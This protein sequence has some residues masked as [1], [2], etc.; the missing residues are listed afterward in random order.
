[1]LQVD[2]PLQSDATMV[3][4]YGSPPYDS[5]TMVGAGPLAGGMDTCQGDSG[6]PL[7]VAGALQPAVVGD[8][9]W[10]AGCAR[11]NLPG[12]YGESW[13]GQMRTFINN[14]V[15]RPANDN[16]ILAQSL[17]GPVGRVSGNN[18]DSTGEVGEPNSAGSAA[19]TT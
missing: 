6:G 10:G 11:A 16:F 7:F 5:A 9:S 8:T 18:T 13:D 15:T 4:A 17:S 2:L 1:L 3:S 19:D 14:N 12:V